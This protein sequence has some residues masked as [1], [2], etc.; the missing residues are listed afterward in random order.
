MAASSADDTGAAGQAGEGD[1]CRDLQALGLRPYEAQVLLALVRAGT[2]DSA[3]LA[4]LSGVPRT[5]IYQVMAGLTAQGLAEEVPSHGPATWL[6]R[7][8]VAV[9][10]RLDAMRE[11]AHRSHRARTARLRRG[12]AQHLPSEPA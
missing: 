5:S 11:E 2:A 7:G 12:L 1:L 3:A 10:D 8:W 6:C 4:R 9:F